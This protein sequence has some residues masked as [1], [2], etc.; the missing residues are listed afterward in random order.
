MLKLLSP[1]Q[2][3][4]PQK[5]ATDK[6]VAG[7]LK[8]QNHQVLLGVTGSGKTFTIAN[9]IAKTKLPTLVMSHNKTLAN[10]L[11][12]E[13]SDFFPQAGVH[14]FISYYDYY[15]PE[16]YIPRS[17]TYIQKD[18]K[19]NE[20]IE[21]MRYATTAD[22][23][24]RKDVIVVASVSCIY[25]ISNPAEYQN[26]SLVFSK[27]QKTSRKQIIENLV[28]LQYKRND[29]AP[30]PGEFSVR[31]EQ[32]NIYPPQG[33][34]KIRLVLDV[35]QIARIEQIPLALGQESRVKKL[36]ETRIFPAKH[37]VTEKQKLKLATK[38]IEAELKENLALLKKQGKL[39]EAERLERRT[40]EDL[41]MMREVGYCAG[42]ENYSRHID[43]RNPGE[44]P[45]TLI[46][47][48]N[49]QYGKSGWLLVIDESHISLPQIRGMHAG[50]H[51]RKKVLVEYG[52]RL[53]SAID[54]RPLKFSEFLERTGKTIY[55]SAT[56]ADY[57]KEK[58]GE[59][60]IIEQLIRPTGI[61]EPKIVIKPASARD[62]QDQVK[63]LIQ[64]I[65]KNIQ[66]GEKTLAIVLTKRQS[67]N[68]TEYLLEQ[69]IKTHWLHSEIKAL[70]RPE[71]LADLRL[72]N[73]DVIVG[74]N[75][76]RE[77]LDLPEVSLI[78]IL[79]ADKEGFLRNQTSLLQIIGRASRH[80]KSK[81]ILYADK[82]TKSIKATLE[83]T[84]RKRKIQL[85]YN[86][87]HGLTPQPI[88][89]PIRQSS[90]V[91]GI[92]SQFKNGN[93]NQVVKV[94]EKEMKK[95]AKD[96]DF[97]KAAKIK[98]QIQNLTNNSRPTTDNKKK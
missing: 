85:D 51:S 2:P 73:V 8:N 19:I 92:E 39:L 76:L 53:P 1:Y 62:G 93:I 22:V 47:Y 29:L 58:S 7:L 4:E 20:Q 32:V 68:L 89:K 49:Y 41:A 81:V 23:L 95:A 90:A 69:E 64:E 59:R 56:P 63:D 13:F 88:I 11:Y 33:K 50:D 83:E 15:Q 43:F 46:D 84:E 30:L 87:K 27:N 31:G 77:G 34:N 16:A 97:E 9:V 38:N 24:S 98:K 80:P 60:N 26:I 35:R 14:Y 65:K 28:E 66:K 6:L 52:F 86:K 36:K 55:V 71:L 17:D 79:D 75:L 61:I 3:I 10:Q 57:E 37:Y 67:E 91:S 48:F 18:A 12:Q 42:I 94:L 72:G 44:P 45:F 82:I 25:G 5:N 78:A 96:W 54:N 74:I 21:Q 40:K 70:D